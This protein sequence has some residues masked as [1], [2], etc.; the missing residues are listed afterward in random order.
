M[1]RKL[2]RVLKAL[3]TKRLLKESI[4]EH[5]IEIKK[6]LPLMGLGWR[7][8]WSKTWGKHYF[9]NMRTGKKLWSLMEV[10]AVQGRTAILDY[11]SLLSHWIHFLPS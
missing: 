5:E 8:F 1:T 6:S 11:T 3:K 7:R 10:Q 9:F 4:K 2:L